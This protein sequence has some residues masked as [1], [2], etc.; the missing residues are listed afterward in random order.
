VRV[1]TAARPVALRIAHLAVE[2]PGSAPLALKRELEERIANALEI[3]ARFGFRE[4]QR[5]VAR[6]RKAEAVTAAYAFKDVGAYG[7]LA[8]QGLPGVNMLIGTRAGQTSNLVAQAAAKAQR[9]TAGLGESE[10]LL[11]A[12][13]AVQRQLHGAV[14]ELVGE[15]LNMGRAAGAKAM[16]QP[17]EFAY[18]SEQLDKDT[19]GPC[20]TEHGGIYQ[21][22]SSEF[23]AHMPPTYCLGAGRC[24][25]VY[26]YGDE[27][28]QF[29]RRADEPTQQ[30]PTRQE[31][32]GDAATRVERR[33]R[34]HEPAVTS[35]IEA[36]AQNAGA[37][38]EGLDFRLKTRDSLE[39][40]IAND[41]IEDRLPIAEAAAKIKDALRYTMSW[42]PSDYV[43]GIQSV[44][45]EMQA[46][47]YNLE[48]F[49]DFWEP[50]DAY[51]GVNAVFS[52]SDGYQFELQFHT[53][54]SFSLKQGEL[55]NL[56]EKWRISLSGPDRD[57]LWD[58]MVE[59]SDSMDFPPNLTGLEGYY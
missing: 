43:G 33:A 10:Q 42:K 2:L 53:Y 36:T 59:L 17:P 58:E 34:A 28:R 56:Y 55:H 1:E 50:G 46:R 12:T 8:K 26:V 35:D 20:V 23:F 21:V 4:V 18:R 3:T 11:A 37:R 41:A 32:P 44:I 57:R 22:N 9:A 48:R 27:S 29:A 14:L 6:L 7:E 25:G 31:T 51:N 45:S 15:S 39:R 30:R 19:C 52:T 13:T 54:E 16:T 40:K 38:T 5:E 47:G 49:K 24:R